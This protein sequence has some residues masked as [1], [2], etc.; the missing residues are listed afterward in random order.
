MKFNKMVQRWGI[1]EFSVEGPQSGNPFAKHHISGVFTGENEQKTAEGFYDGN[2]IYIVRFMP[3]FQ[4]KYQ[5]CITADFLE[6]DQHGEFFVV[7]PEEGNHGPVHVSGE[8]HMAYADGT[9]YYSL[10]TTCY[11]WELQTDQ[12]IDETLDNIYRAGFNKL[13]FCIFPKHYNYNLTDPRSYPYEGSPMDS[14]VLD[15]DNYMDYGPEAEGND[16]DF[17]RFNPKHFQ[18]IE[19]CIQ[20]LGKIGVEADIILWHPYDRWGFSKMTS[21]ENEFYLNYVLARFSAYRNVWW[22]LAN[23][24]DF[25]KYKTI[26]DWERFADIICKKDIYHHLRSI[27]NGHSMYDFTRPWTTHCSIQCQ[28][29]G[30]I[31][32]D[33]ARWREI[34]HKPIVLDEITYEGD[35]GCSYG[36]ISGKELLR[37]FW[38]AACQGGYV[39]HGETFLNDENILWWSHGGALR[40]EC[41]KRIRFL[42]QVLEDVPG[43]GLA[44]VPK[45]WNG[46]VGVPESEAMAG[47]KS[48]FLF[49]YG[50]RQPKVMEMDLTP[51]GSGAGTLYSAELIDT[52][53]MTI[54]H[55]GV[56]CGKFRLDMPGQEYMAVRLKK[57]QS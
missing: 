9:P 48:Y 27:H 1:F 47:E 13:R 29:A 31:G 56:H 25:C 43:H 4:G 34:Y 15:E 18:Q 19:N 44:P 24:Y 16:W 40:G 12:R 49:Y 57:I 30:N 45:Y 23:E 33:V 35:I 50:L 2:G 36:N 26:R 32:A 54:T 21:A 6:N 8:F 20:R 3:S 38:E 7:E 28:L 14:R 37:R 39:G 41:W 42:H 52:W 11:V 51:L 17:T 55:A 53:N 10:G 22:S 46:L 5:F